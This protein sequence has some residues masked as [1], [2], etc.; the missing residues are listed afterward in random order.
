MKKRCGVIKT[1][2]EWCQPKIV[3][4]AMSLLETEIPRYKDQIEY[5]HLCFSTDPFMY[6]KA[7]IHDLS[8]K[9]IDR[10]NHADIR[11]TI[12]TKGVFPIIL[13]QNGFS[14]KNEYGI[15]LVSI[16]EKFRDEY[17]PNAAPFR[18]RIN[19]LQTLHNNGRKTWVSMEPY[20]TPNLVEQDLEKILNEIDFVDKIVFGRLNYNTKSSQW[21]NHK[22]YY[23]DCVDIV[24]SFCKKH[25]IE[26]YIKEGTDTR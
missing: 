19:A 24:L 12:L 13:S 10:L 5:V 4:N 25:G 18:E 6:G 21:E 8:L 1:Y 20:P 15:T 26:S 17:E 23:N 14:K 22:E 7:D 2:E 16:D 9:I 11:C 3:S